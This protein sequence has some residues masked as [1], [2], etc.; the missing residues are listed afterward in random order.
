MACAVA[1]CLVDFVI[2][3]VDAKCALDLPVEATQGSG[4]VRLR[5]VPCRRLRDGY[6]RACRGKQQSCLLQ[7]GDGDSAHFGE[8]RATVVHNGSRWRQQVVQDTSGAPG[9]SRWTILIRCGRC[10]ARCAAS[11]WACR[12][13][14]AC[15]PARV[16][17]SPGTR[18]L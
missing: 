11:S 12:A 18:L 4:S 5:R 7:R 10:G 6:L 14:T 1:R 9:P 3:R 15:P 2:E 8:G 13:S 16:S 17:S